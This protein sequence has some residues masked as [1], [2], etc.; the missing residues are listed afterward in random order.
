[1]I[2]NHKTFWFQLVLDWVYGYQGL[3]V[4]K[5]LWVLDDKVCLTM[6]LINQIQTFHFRTLI[7]VLIRSLTN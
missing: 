4:R 7:F 5:N 2:L 1:M 3:D 6:E